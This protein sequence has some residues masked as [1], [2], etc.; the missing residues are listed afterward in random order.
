M[1]KV[2]RTFP[3]CLGSLASVTPTFFKED[4]KRHQKCEVQ[5]SSN[6]SDPFC[7]NIND[8][9]MQQAGEHGDAALLPDCPPKHVSGMGQNDIITCATIPGE[10]EKRDL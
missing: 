8:H 6:A 9:A 7:T 5:H 4:V 1:F 10:R 2:T 3:Q